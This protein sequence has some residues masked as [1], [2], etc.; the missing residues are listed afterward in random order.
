MYVSSSD[1]LSDN[2]LDVVSSYVGEFDLVGKLDANFA[3]VNG[4]V[5]AIHW[6]GYP[7]ESSMYCQMIGIGR[8]LSRHTLERMNWQPFDCF[9]NSSLDFSMIF[10]LMKVQWSGQLIMN[11]DKI[12]SLSVST[13]LWTN[14]HNFRKLAQG[15]DPRGSE[16]LEQNF[17]EIFTLKN[18]YK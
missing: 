1:W 15:S 11:T 16:W 18:R 12:Q 2:W 17:P 5:N 10:S 7:P 14:I 8:V 4:S 3:H 13:D 9:L 6:K